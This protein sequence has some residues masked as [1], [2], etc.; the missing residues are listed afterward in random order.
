[1]PFY[2]VI[3]MNAQYVTT[4]KVYIDQLKRYQAIE[5]HLARLLGGWLPGVERW[6]VKKQIAYHIWADMQHSQR[7]RTRLWELRITN[8]DRD[9]DA[10]IEKAIEALACAQHDYELIA[11]VYLVLKTELLAA[12]KHYVATTFSVYDYP[13]ILTLNTIIPEL[14]AQINWA[15][16]VVGEL[17]NNGEKR[18]QTQRWLQFAKEIINAMGGVNG[19]KPAQDLPIPPPAYA[20]LLPFS[21]AKRDERFKLQ[22]MGSPMPDENDVMAYMLW[23]FSNY[24]QEMQAAETLATTL[25]EVKGMEWEFYYDVARHCWDE[26]RHSELGENRLNQLGYHIT[27]FPCS[28]GSYGWRQLFNPLIRYCALTYVIEAD[29]FK[30]KHNSYQKYLAEN[31]MESAQAIM[32][33]IMDETMHVRFGQKWVPK[34]M[35]HYQ[36]QK[37]L[38]ALIDECRDIVAKHS[39]SPA[40]RQAALA[41]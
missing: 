37:T 4:A 12:Y 38:Q 14:E 41:K 2:S 36:E 10:G 30:L 24:V 35:P 39:V 40:Q 16:R 13:S 31:D 20:T 17:A 18:R 22:V 19:D 9:V 1:M 28:I 6:E 34:M 29:S 5:T 27:D 25:W 33:D 7:I 32:Y 23:Q 15:S 21:Q 11:G 26:V 8:P 3:K